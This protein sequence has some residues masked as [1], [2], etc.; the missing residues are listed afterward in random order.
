[1]RRTKAA[2]Q[3]E[4]PL[5]ARGWGGRRRGAGRRPGPDPRIPHLRREAFASRHPLHV[6]LKVRRDLPSLRSV[7]LVRELERSFAQASERAGF[8]LVHYSLQADH[9][10][11]IVE[12][13]SREALGR[14]MRS[15][16]ARLARAVNRVFRR[17]GPVLED[18]YHLRVLRTPREVSAALRYVLLNDRRHA[19]RPLPGRVCVDPASSA[20]WF[21]GWRVRVP[22][23]RDPAPVARAHTWLLRTGWRRVGRLHPADVPGPTSA[24]G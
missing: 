21:E 24:R 3:A 16:G 22:R 6:T 2:S 13:T 15:I 11:M 23:A 14:G 4:F 7:R 5:R 1:M 19:R 18:R 10:H 20:R 12:A 8:R 9:A 17:R